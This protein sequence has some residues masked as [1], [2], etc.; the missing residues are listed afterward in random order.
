MVLTLRYYIHST[1]YS[2]YIPYIVYNT[3]FENSEI[4]SLAISLQL[5]GRSETKM[6][7]ETGQIFRQILDSS[8][9]TLAPQVPK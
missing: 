9:F 2:I 4:A 5:S 8:R 3:D 7:S 6:D 1:I